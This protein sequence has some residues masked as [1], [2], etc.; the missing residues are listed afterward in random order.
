[1]IMSA[2]RWRTAWV[3]EQYCCPLESPEVD[4]FTPGVNW[5]QP[6]LSFSRA[7]WPTK[8]STTSGAASP[9]LAASERKEKY[10][11]ASRVTFVI[12]TISIFR[13]CQGATATHLQDKNAAASVHTVCFRRWIPEQ[14]NY[15]LWASNRVGSYKVRPITDSVH[16]IAQLLLGSVGN[17]TK[18]SKILNNN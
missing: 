15:H 16:T 10:Y 2:P 17:I 11:I 7:D 4:A 9:H 13:R 18:F 1:M 12:N 14:V 3:G 6:G 8:P 5:I